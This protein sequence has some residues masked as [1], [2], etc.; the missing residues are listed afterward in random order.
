MSDITLV[1]EKLEQIRDALQRIQR[2]FQFIES[3]D[4]FEA[5]VKSF[6]TYKYEKQ[7]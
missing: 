1:H 2:R 6:R 5:L 7:E 3:P 4:S